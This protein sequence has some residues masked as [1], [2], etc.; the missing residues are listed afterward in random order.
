MVDALLADLTQS[1]L[2]DHPNSTAVANAVALLMTPLVPKGIDRVAALCDDCVGYTPIVLAMAE[3][4]ESTD[5][6]DM[7]R[8]L[9]RFAQALAA[10]EASQ[11]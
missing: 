7:A 10:Y 5:A 1:A 9:R 8:V 6:L 11:L 4:A 2:A 3:H